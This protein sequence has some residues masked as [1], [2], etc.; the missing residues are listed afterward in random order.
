MLVLHGYW[1]SIATYRI[2]CALNLK[3]VAFSEVEHDLLAGE[4]FAPEFRALNPE[5]AVPALEVEGRV[6]TQSYAI[7]DYLDR[8]VPGPSLLPEDPFERAEALALAMAT[9]ADA[10]PLI[11]PR[12]RAALADRF[13]A[14]EA[15][16]T[17]WVLHWLK[18]TL[19][20]YEERLGQR[21][22]APFLFGAD[23]GIA[24][25]ALSSHTVAARAFGAELSDWPRVAAFT[26]RLD[27]VEAFDRAHPTR[28]K[29]AVG[30]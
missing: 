26:A 25:I 23:P 24:D 27:A 21:V 16:V 1:R 17:D 29:E 18:R 8:C 20:T 3:D 22:P 5:A 13:G 14:D 11:V 7:L 12:V 28:R 30:A 10:H 19:D 15:A 2:R 6:L 9:I 4:Q